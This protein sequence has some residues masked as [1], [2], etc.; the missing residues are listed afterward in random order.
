MIVAADTQGGPHTS[1][2]GGWVGA[3]LTADEFFQ[4]PDELTR[5]ELV[6][7][8]V[9]VSPSPTARHQNIVGLIY[10]LLRVF[11]IENQ[12]G[13]PF[14]ELDIHLGKG[15][16]GNDLV[17]RPEV[18][19]LGKD[20]LKGLGNRVVGPPDVVV[21]VVSP[22]SKKLDTVTKKNDYE[23]CGVGE[24]WLIDPEAESMTFY[25]RDNDRFVEIQPEADR[26]QSTA[27]PG[28]TL[29]LAQV[30]KAFTSFDA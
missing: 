9:I 28:F 4:I 22:G 13:L 16:T 20:K 30:K 11:A 12:S 26:F 29:D 8:V 6:D 15:P 23:R 19:F 27:I 21:E 3:R 1:A 14:V 25:R 17:Y 2:A 10:H 5:Y 24:Y 18:S 7:G